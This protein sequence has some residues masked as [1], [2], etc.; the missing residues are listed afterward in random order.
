MRANG[1]TIVELI[2]SVVLLSLISVTVMSR[3]FGTDSFRISAASNQFISSARLAQRIALANS[4]VVIHLKITQV[5]GDWHYLVVEDDGGV[6]TTLY[7]ISVDADDIAILIT[8]GIGP[9]SLSASAAL[10][11]AFD[12]LGN[13][14]DV[15]IGTSQGSV[16]GGVLVQ[17]VGTI[18]R[19]VCISPL[20][21][22]HDGACL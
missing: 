8:A 13:I 10:D 16:S 11:A 6:I 3:W 22:T 2:A 19:I 18:D 9:G 7:T 12:A 17:F 5:S 21:F 15:H 14:T 4:A 1:F 20:G